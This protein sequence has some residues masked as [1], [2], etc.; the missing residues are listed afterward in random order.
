MC[1]SLRVGGKE[2]KECMGVMVEYAVKA[3]LERNEAIWK[4]VL[5]ARDE[6]AK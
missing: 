5:E 2:P 1:G 4:E 3:T 6:N